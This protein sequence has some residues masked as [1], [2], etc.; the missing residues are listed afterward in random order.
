[1]T[2]DSILNKGAPM[3][4]TTELGIAPEQ[5]A[6]VETAGEE[7][8]T[9][10]VQSTTEESSTAPIEIDGT[11][12]SEE[13]LRGAVQGGLRQEDYTRKTQALADRRREVEG[14]EEELRLWEEELRRKQEHQPSLPAQEDEWGEEEE[15]DGM[16]SLRG[17]IAELRTMISDNHQR[18]E[19]KRVQE[20]A[21]RELESAL[22]DLDGK[23][24][25]DR[26]EVLTYMHERGMSDP[27]Q[28]EVAYQAI[29]GVRVGKHLGERA[30][31]ERGGT[32]PTVMG[33]GQSA[34]SPGFTTPTEVPGVRGGVSEMSW[35]DLKRNA[36]K[37]AGY[38]E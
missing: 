23:P 16:T 38:S 27:A 26:A 14:K 5:T 4:P 2:Q 32:A 24:Y 30:A 11:Q 36:Q 13:E 31:A 35:D 7:G 33:T 3:Y 6:A 18:E 10:E 21:D 37:S 9:A 17:E 34:T 28:A 22:G 12:Y 1:M 20:E 25:F 15:T 29:N 8:S 19:Q